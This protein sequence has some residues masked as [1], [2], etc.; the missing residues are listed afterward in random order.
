M[1]LDI[2]TAIVAGGKI[3]ASLAAGKPIPSEWLVDSEGRP[4]SDGNLY[5][6][7]ASLSP[8]GGHKGYG[9]ALMID[10]LSG[11][12]SGSSVRDKIGPWMDDIANP[13]DHGHAFLAISP[14]VIL[15]GN[16]FG[17]RMTTLVHG[18]K[19]SPTVPEAGS[20]KIPGEIEAR[21]AE[22]SKK[23]GIPL[24]D[25]VWESLQGAAT[26]AGISLPD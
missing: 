4:T 1:V 2:S 6:Y 26:D 19:Q 10:V 15:G 13:T 20:L 3:R 25:D 24:P 12:M 9:L 18:I 17:G 14:S 8:M 22:A 16:T 23:D 21:N 11:L 7:K 5:P